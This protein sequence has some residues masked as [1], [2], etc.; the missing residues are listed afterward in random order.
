MSVCNQE[1]HAFSYF[2]WKSVSEKNG[3]I[4]EYREEREQAKWRV[5]M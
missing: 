5:E 1:Q 3:T 2:S 4:C